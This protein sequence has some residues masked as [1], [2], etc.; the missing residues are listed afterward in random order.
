MASGASVTSSSRSHLSQSAMFH[1]ASF[2]AG[3]ASATSPRLLG[4][5]L[6]RVYGFPEE[7]RCATHRTAE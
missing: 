7:S 1:F 4:D 3:V 6:P 5:V 2:V